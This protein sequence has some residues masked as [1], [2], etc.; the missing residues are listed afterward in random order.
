MRIFIS[1]KILSNTTAT[2]PGLTH[3][4]PPL[5][6]RDWKA[7]L[8]FLGVC[9]ILYLWGGAGDAGI[10]NKC[11]NKWPKRTE[12]CLSTQVFCISK[13]TVNCVPWAVGSHSGIR[14]HSCYLECPYRQWQREKDAACTLRCRSERTCHFHLKFT[15]W[16]KWLATLISEQECEHSAGKERNLNASSS[17]ESCHWCN[18]D[19]RTTTESQGL[20]ERN[21]HGGHAPSALHP[22]HGT[23]SFQLDVNVIS[24]A[25]A[26]TLRWDGLVN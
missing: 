4:E 3:W 5:Y 26:A 1:D 18:S 23:L 21:R 7:T 16:W 14:A 24:R 12:T 15:D 19:Q 20:Q 13:A 22:L 10:T 2:G 9:V 25:G 17:C 11:Q 8:T 6:N